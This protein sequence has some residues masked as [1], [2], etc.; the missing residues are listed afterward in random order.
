M[1]K[2]MA[3]EGKGLKTKFVQLCPLECSDYYLDEKIR[4]CTFS[5]QSGFII[6]LR[7]ETQTLEAFE[8]P[9]GLTQCV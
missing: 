3:I 1:A 4:I 9:T 2:A 8:A 6:A 5:V 7:R